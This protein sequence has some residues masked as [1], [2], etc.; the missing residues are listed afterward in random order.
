MSDCRGKQPTDPFLVCSKETAR[1]TAR[2]ASD[3]R[4]RHRVVCWII[5]SAARISYGPSTHMGAGVA[6]SPHCV[7]PVM[8]EPVKGKTAAPASS[9]QE[10]YDRASSS[11]SGT[12]GEAFDGLAST[13][14]GVCPTIPKDHRGFAVRQFRDAPKSIWSRRA[15]VRRQPSIRKHRTNRAPSHGG[16]FVSRPRRRSDTSASEKASAL[17]FGCGRKVRTR[18]PFASRHVMKVSRFTE[19]PKR[20][21]P[22]DNVDNGHKS[23]LALQA[24]LRPSATPAPGARLPVR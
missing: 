15:T 4:R 7:G 3:E 10:E 21:L 22:V 2:Q 8:I 13:P 18:K 20:N 14:F 16:G 19:S 5:E 24:L 6:A 1:G 9:R 11:C 12:R 23:A 17:R